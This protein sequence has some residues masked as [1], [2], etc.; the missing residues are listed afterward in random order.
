MPVS[1][2][3]DNYSFVIVS[4]GIRKCESFNFVPLF[5]DGLAIVSPV[6]FP[7]NFMISLSVSAKEPAEILIRILLTL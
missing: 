7:V 2:R 1:C 3:V 5:Q 4:F 6:N